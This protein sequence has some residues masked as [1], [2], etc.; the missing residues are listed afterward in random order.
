VIAMPG[1]EEKDDGKIRKQEEDYTPQVDEALPKAVALAT[2]GKLR[3]AVDGLLPLEKKARIANDAHSTSRILEA[4]VTM[5][6]DAKD[7][8][9]MGEYVILL[10]KRRGAL[11]MAVTK[12]VQKAFDYLDS[13][14]DKETM[15][16]LIDTLR[17]VTAGKIHVEIERARLTMKLSKIKEADGDIAGAATVLHD[18]QVETFGS[19]DRK[20]KVEYIL[21][22]MRL[23]LATDDFIRT[24]ILS[25]KLSTKVFD[26]EEYQDLK[27]KFYYMMIRVA[28]SEANYLDIC[29]YSRQV[30]DTPKVKEDLEESSKALQAT[31]I[32][33]VL[34][35]YDN[36]QSDLVARVAAEEKLASVPLF[37][38]L[39][40]QF[41]AQEIMLW[42][43]VDSAYGPVL[44]ATE[45]FDQSAE[46]GKK[47]YT[48]L[49]RR[50]VEHNIQV[51]AKYYTKITVTRLSELLELEQEKMEEFLSTLVVNKTVWAKIDRPAGIVTFAEPQNATTV[52]EAWSSEANELMKLVDRASHMIQKERVHTK[53]A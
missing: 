27:L 48:D 41:T 50:V 45:H 5:C 31:V 17:T 34:S 22:Q 43:K 14:P 7:W 32:Y 4:V 28:K 30:F 46:D 40:E 13:T 38:A 1:D 23:G 52:L 53:K 24:A 37:K 9:A 2:S 33:L 19:M 6:Y 26:S 47:R 51:M 8:D 25:K 35:P 21:E 44:K 20:E 42:S 39:L 3:E 29:R 18:V 12:M 36:E 49:K 10:T 11:K 16:K 15:L